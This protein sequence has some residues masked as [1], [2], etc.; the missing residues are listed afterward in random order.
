MTLSS[1]DKFLL[2]C[3]GVI[4]GVAAVFGGVKLAKKL[5]N[6]KFAKYRELKPLRQQAKE[7]QTTYTILKQEETELQVGHEK[8]TKYLDMC[9]N[10]KTNSYDQ[11]PGS[12]IFLDFNDLQNR[13]QVMSTLLQSTKANIIATET[14]LLTLYDLLHS[15]G[16]STLDAFE[17]RWNDMIFASA[18]KRMRMQ[19]EDENKRNEIR[20]RREED[21]AY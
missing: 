7:L 10:E 3:V 21:G 18:N 15:Q 13:V 2:G 12:G 20:Q 8:L 14:R 6:S 17:E 19:E 16:D 5:K 1:E 9:W 11:M 4:A